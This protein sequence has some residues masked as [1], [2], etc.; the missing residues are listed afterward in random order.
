VDY[1]LIKEGAMSGK[2]SVKHDCIPESEFE[3]LNMAGSQFTNINLSKARF[4]DI[5]FSDVSFTAALIGGT[6]FKHLG[7]MPDKDGKQE[8]QRPVT[9]EE[10]M[11]CDSVFHFMDMT[12]VKIID[13]DVTGMTINGILVTDLLAEWK[14][15]HA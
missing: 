12:G 3:D 8:R 13:C 10:G 4:H 11:L 14:K 1:P 15:R 7:P 2:V 6:T 5:N 9:F